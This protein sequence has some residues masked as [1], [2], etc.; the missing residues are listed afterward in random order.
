[1]ESTIPVGNDHAVCQV[2]SKKLGISFSF[3]VA[4][5]ENQLTFSMEDSSIQETGK[6]RLAS[7]SF[8]NFFGCVYEDTIPG[9]LLVPDGSGAL[10]RFQKTK[11]YGSGYN[12]KV[13]GY[14]LAIEQNQ[15]LSNL[16]GNRT[17]D[18]ATEE[19][20]LSLPVWGMVHGENQ[21]GFLAMIDH[22]EEYAAISAIPAG[23]ETESVKFTR[24]YATFI[25][26]TAYNVRVSSSRA[27]EIIPEE[28]NPINPELT[29]LFLS[30]QDANYSGMAR[31]CRERL[32]A[33]EKLPQ[34]KEEGEKEK[35]EEVS[36]EE[37]PGIP[38][39]LHAVGSETKEGFLTNE[40]IVLT[41]A[42]QVEE[43]RQSLYNSG[44]ANLTLLLSG[45]MKGGYHGAVYGTCKFERRV[46]N[47]SEIEALRE[48]VTE[49]GGHLVLT[50]NPMTA[51]KDQI[52][53]KRQA[54]LNTMTDPIKE[55]VPNQSLMYPDTYYLSHSQAIGF[56]QKASDTLSDFELLLEGAARY[57]YSDFTVDDERNR[58]GMKEALESSISACEQ[59]IWLD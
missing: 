46:G 7:V 50:V 21:N 57:L 17:D 56:I 9:Y 5:S 37:M 30:G 51:N 54:A 59:P 43:M 34:K 32:I 15:T 44:I 16:N 22:G 35:S 20:S 55:T 40:Q 14:D 47:R 26:R 33:Q 53:Y 12:K 45:W 29:F 41:T 1:M 3:Q 18:Y 11:V 58:T 52:Q 38:L 19:F 42:S 48:Q 8:V 49:N 4:L 6:S 27:V 13:Y 31:I 25:Y 36:G 39:L 10:I 23:A 2:S 28:R 24:A